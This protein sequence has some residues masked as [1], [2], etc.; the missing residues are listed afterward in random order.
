MGVDTACTAG[1]LLQQ[2]LALWCYECFEAGRCKAQR[3]KSDGPVFDERSSPSCW[4]AQLIRHVGA[5][6]MLALAATAPWQLPMQSPLA[7]H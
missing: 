5:S 3:Q 2:Q 6:H 1:A 7:T 4:A